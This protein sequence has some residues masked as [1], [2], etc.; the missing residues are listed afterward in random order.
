L[1]QESSTTDESAGNATPPPPPWTKATLDDLSEFDF[2]EPV[3]LSDSADAADLGDIYRKVAGELPTSSETAAF[4]VYSMLAAIMGMHFK[5]NE[6]NE[7]FGAM[8][9]WADGRRSA[10][11]ADFR[12]AAEVLV[13]MAKRAEHPVL[14]ARLA[15]LCWQLDR[16]RGRL[17]VA[18]ASAYVEIVSKVD[19]DTLK[20]RFDPEQ[21]GAL[22]HQARDLLK[23]ALFIGR[24]TGMDK[25]GPS[26]AQKLVA[27]LRKRAIDKHLPRS[28]QMFGRL[29]LHFGISDAAQV[30]KDIETLITG[31]PAE[32]DAQ[33][34]V[35]T[36]H[37]CVRE[38]IKAGSETDILSAA[39]TSDCSDLLE[40]VDLWVYGHTHES[41]DFTVGRTRIVSNS[42]G[43]GPWPA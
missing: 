36:H 7:P 3:R 21:T 29:D 8:V 4:R 5:P 19:A 28:V 23:R 20:F 6:P 17:G 14:R 13:E 34:V 18:A 12:D 10:I 22:R 42:K 2:E 1:T 30:G 38:A 9:V 33:T 24:G 15:D 26:E 37:G 27:D 16:K 25:N 41:R 32:T 35:V 39:Y 40:N 31:L 43:Y 11:P